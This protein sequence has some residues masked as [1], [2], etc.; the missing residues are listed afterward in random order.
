M[1]MLDATTDVS[2]FLG[3]KMSGGSSPAGRPNLAEAEDC[4]LD[5]VSELRSP[6]FEADD[7][8]PDFEADDCRPD[9]EA[10]D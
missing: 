3:E 6:D 5:L 10:D 9:F 2:V 8:R 1:D 4:K 7:C